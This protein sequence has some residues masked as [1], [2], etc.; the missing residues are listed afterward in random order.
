MS[1]NTETT[2]NRPPFPRLGEIYLE[3]ALALDLKKESQNFKNLYKNINRLAREGDYDWSLL[4][5][6]CKE[7]ISKPL[8]EQ[9]DE[10]FSELIES[11]ILEIHEK[12]LYIVTNIS[13]DN[14]SRQDTIPLLVNNYFSV[15]GC[16]LISH[17]HE[18]FGGPDIA[19]FLDHH[20]NP[21][22]VV[23]DWANQFSDDPSVKSLIKMAFPETMDEDKTNRD[24]ANRWVCGKQLPDLNSIQKFVKKLKNQNF[25]K[26]ENLCRW[27]LIARALAYFEEKFPGL[28]HT[29][30]QYFQDRLQVI[31]IVPVLCDAVIQKG[32]SWAELSRAGAMLHHTLRRTSKKL[33]GDNLKRLADIENL[34][35]LAKQHDPEGLLQFHLEWLEGRWHVL[36]GDLKKALPF[37]KKAAELVNYRGGDA[38]KE[39]TQEALVIASCL[40]T[41]DKAFIKQLKHRAIVFKLFIEPTVGENKKSQKK[42]KYNVVE[43]WEIT[44]F[45]QQFHSIFPEQGRFFEFTPGQIGELELPILI[46]NSEDISGMK[47]D[48]RNPNQIKKIKFESGQIRRYPQLRFFASVGRVNEVTKLLEND[49]SVDKLDEANASALLC[50]IQYAENTGEREVLDILL[51]KEHSKETLNKA[52]DKKQ[53][54]PLMCAIDYGQPDVIEKLLKMGADPDQCVNVDNQTPLYECTNMMGRLMNPQRLS[55]SLQSSMFNPNMMQREVVRRQSTSGV[56]GDAGFFQSSGNA[57]FK[58][59]FLIHGIP[60]FVEHEV[61]KHS[62]EN[63]FKI[64]Q[65]LLENKADPNAANI[66]PYGRTP[67]MQAAEYN[68]VDIFDLMC[69]HGGD[70]AKEDTYHDD[71][72]KIAKSFSSQDVIDYL[73]NK[74]SMA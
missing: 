9:T 31:H 44:Q 45:R 59:A 42:T 11:F 12:Y 74:K 71:C 19:C 35:N 32:N 17:I 46:W 47:A 14:M 36:S 20:L 21:I 8:K 43:D 30:H 72:M 7:L 18:K 25:T 28:R 26:Y 54:T 52:T 65:L 24:T 22:K 48:L 49:A 23:L 27:L 56:F 15:N 6:L 58:A 55:K 38:Q 29:M 37:Y 34:K 10:E 67:L 53:L 1:Q 64:I 13:L 70:P 66:F 68:L 62:K 73:N 61:K 4:S 63:L 40:K 41:P 3:L 33:A 60:A 5:T 51:K 2:T 57:D 69:K 50:A 39:I 16:L